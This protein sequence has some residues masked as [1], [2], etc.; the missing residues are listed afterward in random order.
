MNKVIVSMP[1]EFD[2][3]RLR[4]DCRTM[5]TYCE[6]THRDVDEMVGSQVMNS[7]M[8]ETKRDYMPTLRNFLT[9]C[10]V[11]DLDPRRYFRLAE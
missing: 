9:L 1:V 5:M 6:L 4:K 10:N 2:L 11:L 3:E 7:V 8:S